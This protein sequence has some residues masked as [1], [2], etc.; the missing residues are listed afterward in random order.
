MMTMQGLPDDE[1]ALVVS[2]PFNI[3]LA[4]GSQPYC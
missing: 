4:D 3:I 1:N 2:P